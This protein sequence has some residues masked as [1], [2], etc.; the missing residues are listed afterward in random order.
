MIII[1]TWIDL[2]DEMKDD[3]L[4]S[5]TENIEPDDLDI[6]LDDFELEIEFE[7]KV[8]ISTIDL[9]KKDKYKS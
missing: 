9:V 6:N 1:T 8:N 4:I 3:I 7:V 2:T 5:I